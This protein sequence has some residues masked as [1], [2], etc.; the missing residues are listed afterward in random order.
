VAGWKGLWISPTLNDDPPL[1]GVEAFYCD[2]GIA[3]LA[4]GH[5]TLAAENCE[6]DCLSSEVN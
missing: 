1:S 3:A 5:T 4:A 2:I 6:K